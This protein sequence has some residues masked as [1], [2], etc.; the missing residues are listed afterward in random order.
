[1]ALLT[2]ACSTPEQGG[3]TA[4]DTAAQPDSAADA[5]G[6]VAA[7][8]DSS[9]DAQ[10]DAQIDAQVDA[11]VDAASD[12]AVSTDAKASPDT[13]S[14]ASASPDTTTDPALAHCA[15]M[16]PLPPFANHDTNGPRASCAG[17]DVVLSVWAPGVIRVAH[18]WSGFKLPPQPSGRR[19]AVIAPWAPTAKYRVTALK[20]RLQV[21]TE[22]LIA[23]VDKDCRLE[24]TDADGKPL[25]ADDAGSGW[26]PG[27]GGQGHWTLSRP[28]PKGERFYGLGERDTAMDRRGGAWT[29]WNTDAYDPKYG[30][31][32]PGQDPL[33][34]NI[35]FWMARRPDGRVWGMLIDTR[36]KA[37]LDLAES[38]P[39]RWTWKATGG[40]ADTWIFAGPTMADV[41]RR[42]TGLTGRYKVPPLWTLGYHQC[43]WGYKDAAEVLAIAS[44]LRKRKLPAESMW[45]DI[46]HMDG[47]R[48]FTW[49]PKHFKDPKALTTALAKQ[50]FRTIAIVDPGLKADPGWSVYGAGAKHFIQ[51]SGKPFLAKAWPGLAAWPDFTRPATRTWWAGLIAEFVKVGLDGIWL[52]L[53]EP[54]T[55][56]EGGGGTTLPNTLAIHGDGAQ[57]T[58][59]QGHEVYALDESRATVDGM[60]KA[61]PAK[62]PWVLSRAGY[63]G[64]QRTAAIWTGDVPSTWEGIAGTMPMMLGL[65]LSGVPMVGSDVG[66]YSGKPGPELF[67][68]WMALGVVSPLLRNHVTNGVPGQEPYKLGEEVEAISRGLLAWR[69]ELLPTLYSLMAEAAVNG[70][71]PLRPMVWHFPGDDALANVGSQAML[72]PWLLV[73][74]ALTKGAKARKI[75]LPAGRWFQWHSA[76]AFDGPATIEADLRLAALPRYVREGAIL[77]LGPARQHTGDNT[78][79]LL[80]LELYPKT[81]VTTETELYEDA[82]DGPAAWDPANKAWA[83]TRY[84][85]TG[86][87]AGATLVAGPRNGDHKPPARPVEVRIR[88]VDHAPGKDPV[89]L[90][91]KPL[92]ARKSLAELRASASGWWWDADDLSLR[93]RFPD[94]DGFTLTATYN[95]ALKALSP[96][97][98]VR[99]EVSVPKGTPATDT[100]RVVTDADGWKTQHKLAWKTAGKVAVGA[101]A[102][103]RGKWFDYKFTRGG[104]CTV[105]KWPGCKEADNRYGMA[106]A[107][108]IRA[109]TVFGWRDWC[110]GKCP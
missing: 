81:G 33:Y 60:S 55:F 83:R 26:K 53:N 93:V 15:P 107:W 43:R 97:V 66:G 90:D 51:H 39:S 77:L 40:L 94:K 87:K 85:L 64:I 11:Q 37:T 22:G 21:C 48:S 71:P 47:F 104:W 99:F 49:H 59:A 5:Q 14:D 17:Q 78:P 75:K 12:N 7:T 80:R 42:Y 13:A 73:A 16:A 38:D 3:G 108:P 89:K 110:P 6:D 84:R 68:R 9:A 19:W 50:G 65:G 76:A 30:G 101:V 4:P 52:D 69:Y 31:Y 2:A 92:P 34:V 29:F 41:M 10:V 46:Q 91:G 61:F 25:S 36:H 27:A 56:P 18:V 79:P 82:G 28:T 62:R 103:P 95:P 67:A 72:G 20:G 70:A 63:A 45:L 74:P 102:L 54:T 32:A 57:T 44:E 88:R 58:M 23:H 98:K 35:P 24:I 105:E 86:S 109:E 8:P 1:V 106:A 96:P 100:L